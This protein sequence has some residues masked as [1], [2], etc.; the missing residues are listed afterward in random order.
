[1]TRRIVIAGGTGH[2]GRRLAAALVARGDDVVVLSRD[3]DRASADDATRGRLARWSAADPV[4]LAQLLDG[5][6]AVV[7]VTGVPVGPLPWT[8]GR[9]RAIRASRLEPTRAMVEAIRTLPPSHRPGAFVS[10]SGT[11]G[12]E[13]QD[14]TPATE[15][16]T[17]GGG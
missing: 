5:A 11:D 13:G 15:Q 10:V 9:R 4:G 17:T 14:D 6:A 7:G 8:A 12:Y 3:P 2:I 1:M 16:S